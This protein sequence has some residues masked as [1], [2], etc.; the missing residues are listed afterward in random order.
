MLSNPSGIT[1]RRKDAENDMSKISLMSLLSFARFL[2]A[3]VFLM[4]VNFF[5]LRESTERLSS[6]VV[7]TEM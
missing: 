2:N 1:N 3:C 5:T 7:D 4:R 6:W